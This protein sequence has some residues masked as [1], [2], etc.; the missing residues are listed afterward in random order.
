[1]LQKLNSDYGFICEGGLDLSALAQSKDLTLK[2]QGLKVGAQECSDNT[3]L[4][5][6]HFFLS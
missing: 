4:L 6:M 1:M 5:C 2:H 3:T